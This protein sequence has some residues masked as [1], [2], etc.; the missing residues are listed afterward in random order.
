MRKP[1]FC[2]CKHKGAD[3]LRIE[4]NQHL[5][6]RYIDS[7]INPSTSYNPNFKPL[8]IFCGCTAPFVL[9]L[10]GNTED[11]FSHEAVHFTAHHAHQEHPN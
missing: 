7:T 10:V 11:R 4:A 3:Q 2:I 6:F 5:G 1:A 8:A 9:D